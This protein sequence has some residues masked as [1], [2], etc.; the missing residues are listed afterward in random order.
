MLT[1]ASL[2]IDHNEASY[3]PLNFLV[4]VKLLNDKMIVSTNIASMILRKYGQSVLQ[5]L[6]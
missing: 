4:K 5:S 1:L 6:C 2:K 3:L